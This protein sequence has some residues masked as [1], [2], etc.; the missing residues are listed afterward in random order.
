MNPP[1]ICLQDTGIHQYFVGDKAKRFAINYYRIV[2]K[3]DGSDQLR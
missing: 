3:T 2:S 1:L